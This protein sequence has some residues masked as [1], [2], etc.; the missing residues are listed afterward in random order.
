M[1]IVF[2]FKYFSGYVKNGVVYVNM[3]WDKGE[4]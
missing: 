4:G 3:P 1:L 2:A